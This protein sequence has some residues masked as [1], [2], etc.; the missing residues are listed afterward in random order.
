MLGNQFRSDAFLITNASD[1]SEIVSL[2]LQNPPAGAKAGWLQISQAIWMDTYQ[3]TP[4]ADALLPVVLSNG[5]QE[6]T[7]PAGFTAKIWLTVDSSKVP[8]G[9]YK[10][11]FTVNGQEIPFHLNISKIA[12]QRPRLSLTAWDYTDPASMK[13][14]ASRGITTANYD[15]ALAMMKSHFVDSPWATRGIL[16]IPDAEDF[17]A[18]NQLK[19]TLT[20][21]NFDKWIAQWPEARQYFVFISAKDKEAFAGSERG[22]AEFKARLGS[23]AK[24]LSAHMKKLNH[25]PAKLALLIVDEPHLEWQDDVIAD[26]ASA[27]NAAAPELSLLCDPAWAKPE[28]ASHQPALTQMD[29]LMP[30]TQRYAGSYTDASKAYFDQRREAGTDLWLYSC[31]GP[32]RLFN[33]QQYYRGQAWRVFAM[34]GKGMGYWAFGDIA[35]VPSTWNDYQISSS[36]APAFIEKDTVH[37]SIHWDATREGVEDFEE[38]AML[39]DAIGKTSNAHLKSQAQALLDEVIKTVTATRTTDMWNDEKQP[40]MVDAQLQKVREML[41][42]LQ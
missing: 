28:E 6:V 10:S 42:A 40:Q 41:E 33:P 17:D 11:T 21:T 36:F 37:N 15:A 27:I 8:S 22:T 12:M 19:S 31:T 20:F 9:N 25:D 24:A 26:W 18:N 7:I 13:G 29:M 4:V 32:A 38:L 30:N 5:L 1:A 23:W 35:G 2:K 3:G 14:V 16:P 34:D 39:R